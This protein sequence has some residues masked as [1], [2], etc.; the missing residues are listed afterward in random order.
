MWVFWV[1]VSNASRFEQSF[2]DIVNYVKIPGRQ[3][4][5]ANIFQLVYDWLRNDRKGKWVLILDNVD[6]A[7][8]LVQA[9]STGIEVQTNNISSG[10]S[11]PLIVYLP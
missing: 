11:Q 9:Q 10:N 3:N 5:Q 1:H 8:F 6:D 4:L 2:R 7:G